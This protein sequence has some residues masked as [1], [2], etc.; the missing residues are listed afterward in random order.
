[1]VRMINKRFGT[2][3]LVAE[4]RV[5][6]YLAAGHK[7]AASDTKPASKKPKN[8]TKPTKK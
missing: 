1:M 5:E 3:M 4:D 8:K 2:E 6:E 7:L